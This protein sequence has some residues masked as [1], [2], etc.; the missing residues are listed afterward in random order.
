MAGLKLKKKDQKRLD[1]AVNRVAGIKSAL[2][3]L[4]EALGLAEN[5]MWSV[6]KE[7]SGGKEIQRIAHN[8]KNAIILKD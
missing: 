1:E 4:S 6:A 5:E 2:M 3:S 8:P 7:L